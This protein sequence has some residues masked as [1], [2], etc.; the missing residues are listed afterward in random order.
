MNSDDK[1]L[2]KH[3][4]PVEIRFGDID[5]MG[6]VNNARYFT[7]FEQGRINFL[8]SVLGTNIKYAERGIIVANAHADFKIP[9]LFRDK[10]SVLTRVSKIGTKSFELSYSLV[11]D[12]NGIRRECASGF[13]TMVCFDYREQHSVEIPEE[14][15]MMFIELLK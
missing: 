8:D 3:T 9:V 5:A 15:R 13:T 12:E 11:K 2:F 10:I 14:W 1:K 7:Y 6:H 4:T